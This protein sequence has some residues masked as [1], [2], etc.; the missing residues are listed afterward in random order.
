MFYAYFA[1]ALC[2]LKSP[3]L[4]TEDPSLFL[5]DHL[6][7]GDVCSEQG[8]AAY[9]SAGSPPPRPSVFHP[10]SESIFTFYDSFVS[11]TLGVTSSDQDNIS[12]KISGVFVPAY[13]GEYVFQ[14]FIS[15][16]TTTGICHWNLN[17][18]PVVIELDMSVA[19]SGSSGD[20]SCSSTKSTSTC[21]LTTSYT[22]WYS[23]TR[24][25]NL[26]Q[27]ESYPI[28]AGTRYDWGVPYG[29][30][31]LGLTL[32]YTDP[33]GE[34]KKV[35][36]SDAYL[37]ISGYTLTPT[38]SASSKPSPT[39]SRSPVPTSSPSISAS[40]IP[41]K[42]ASISNSLHYSNTSTSIVGDASSSDTSDLSSDGNSKEATPATV[43]VVSAG[44]IV[45][46]IIVVVALWVILRKRRKDGETRKSQR[47]KSSEG[48]RNG[49][50][51]HQ[52]GGS[53][54][55][56]SGGGSRQGSGG[57]SRRRSDGG[58]RQG[59]GGSSRRRSG[60]SSRRRSGGGS[61]RGSGGSSRRRSDGGSRQ[62]SGGSSRRRSDGG[63]RRG[64]GGSIRRRI[65]DGVPPMKW[66]FESKKS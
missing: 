40:I 9:V 46:I 65:G 37:G 2:F 58:S 39:P 32:S 28:F 3:R 21:F 33:E 34:T 66:C 16:I 7:E 30:Y 22:N 49:G 53:S 48:S 25:Y 14:L 10:I 29:G 52:D 12:G 15:H 5:C 61:R 18:W 20:L 54:R 62:G 11:D 59:S 23:C 38:P 42:T 63:S 47:S 1:F 35:G 50:N 27:Y 57:S 19:G 43:G 44:V 55:R 8:V 60:G 51:S 31:D 56:R 17:T 26:V 41:S 45:I 4:P 13:T 6:I 36:S 64:S 24:T